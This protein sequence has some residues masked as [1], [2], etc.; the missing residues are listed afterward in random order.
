MNG[1]LIGV[2][3]GP[4]SPDL[5][6]LR[7]LKTLES[8][9]VVFAP[10]MAL[11]VESRAESIATKA[12]PGLVVQRLVFAILRD[13][14]TRHRAHQQAALVVNN[15]LLDGATAAFITLGDPNIYSTFHHLAAEVKAL[16]PA[17]VIETVPGIMAFQAL[18]SD[19]SIVVT[20]DVEKLR[21]VTAVDG[22]DDVEDALTDTSSAVVIYKGGRRFSDIASLLD[23]CGRLKGAYFGELLGLDSPT[24]AQVAEVAKEPAAYLSTIV[25]PPKRSPQ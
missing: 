24:V 23:R 12:L 3:V 13:S 14:D 16:Q 7:A 21:I 10:S 1:T 9:D 15:A 19:A 20:D 11:D 4:G 8:A 17:I 22:L 2:G 18:A 5:L 6:T 25:V